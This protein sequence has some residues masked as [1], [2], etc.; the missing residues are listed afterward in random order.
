MKKFLSILLALSILCGSA[1]AVTGLFSLEGSRDDDLLTVRITLNQEISA[2]NASMLQG[3]LYYDPEV[4]V[5]VSVTAGDDYGFLTCVISQRQPRVQFSHA[6][7]DSLPL[8]LAGGTVITAQFESLSDADADLRLELALHTANGAVVADLTE[9][10][11]IEYRRE[12]EN[13]FRDV[14]EDSFY[15]LPVLWAVEN[16]ITNGASADTFNPGGDLLRAQVVVMLWRAAGSPEPTNMDNPFTDVKDTDFYCKA[17]LWAVE[18]GITNGTSATTFSPMGITNRAQVVTFLWRYLGQP[19]S[20]AENPFAD[21]DANAWY[22]PSVLWAVEN[23]ITNGMSATQF[24]VG[25]NCNRAHM[26]TF[27]YRALN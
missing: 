18:N 4:L 11:T 10:A 3:E 17:V 23:G 5:P 12:P 15:F 13:P 27:L 22:G 2:E 26:V 9:Y 14:P 1:Y 6:D 25:T 20:S 16:G 7:E 21:V 8:T 24:G 19:G